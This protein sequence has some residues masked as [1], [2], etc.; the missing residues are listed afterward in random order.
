MLYS[1]ENPSNDRERE[2]NL[3]QQ[4]GGGVS[5]EA[6]SS[7][8]VRGEKEDRNGFPKTSGKHFFVIVTTR[9]KWSLSDQANK[10]SIQHRTIVSS[11]VSVG[12]FCRLSLGLWRLEIDEG[13]KKDFM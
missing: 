4:P 1:N 11:K 3:V 6:I 7:W 10:Y 5:N 9:K 12:Q 2:R 13:S 8:S